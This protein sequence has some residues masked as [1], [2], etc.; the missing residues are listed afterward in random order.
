MLQTA[1]KNGL[2][3]AKGDPLG[4]K[5]L[6]YKRL[7]NSSTT[8]ESL[9]IKVTVAAPGSGAEEPNTKVLV[10]FP[11]SIVLSILICLKVIVIYLKWQI[12][13]CLLFT[14][15]LQMLR[16]WIVIFC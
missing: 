15:I 8:E 10:M 13:F 6:G 7:L 14:F 16:V 5:S 9:Q 1:S 11:S 4:E 12:A 2:G 3:D